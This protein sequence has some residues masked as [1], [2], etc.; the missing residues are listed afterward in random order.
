MLCL[1]FTN[2]GS[3]PHTRGTLHI[4]RLASPFS[5]F[6]PA[7]AGNILRRTRHSFFTP[8]HPRT[9]GEH[10]SPRPF[11]RSSPGSSPHTRGTWEQWEDVKYTVRFIPA[12]AGNILCCLICS[13]IFSVHPR[14]RGEHLKNKIFIFYFSGSSPHTRGTCIYRHIVNVA[15]RFIPAH[16]GNISVAGKAHGQGPVHPRTRGEHNVSRL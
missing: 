1:I 12:H 11:I 15:M 16:A 4:L 7:H 2:V 3:S 10:N 13:R 14:T 8:V 6:I 9:R 5:R